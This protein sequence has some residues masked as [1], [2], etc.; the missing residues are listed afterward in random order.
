MFKKL[1]HLMRFYMI[2]IS[3]TLAFQFPLLVSNYSIVEGFNYMDYHGEQLFD[4]LTVILT[5]AVDILIIV[6][7][8]IFMINLFLQ[9]L[10]L[11]RLVKFLTRSLCSRV[12]IYI[13][14]VP[15]AFLYTHD[16]I[17]MLFYCWGSPAFK[18]TQASKDANDNWTNKIDF[19]LFQVHEYEDDSASQRDP[20]LHWLTLSRYISQVSRLIWTIVLF[21]SMFYLQTNGT[22]SSNLK[23]RV[24]S[25][26]SSLRIRTMSS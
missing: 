11:G 26:S 9:I 15:L 4:K 12:T 10:S 6:F 2:F 23:V 1:K 25:M 24:R 14:L 16:V 13:I 7:F 21:S 5:I 20:R 18:M 17:A 22:S 3:A 8:L 19:C